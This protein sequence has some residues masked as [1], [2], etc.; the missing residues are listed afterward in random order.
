MVKQLVSNI[1]WLSHASFRIEGDGLVIYID[2]WKLKDGPKADLILITHDHHD[3]CS[4]TDVA[5]VQQEDTVIVT[6]AAAAAKLTGQVK[7]VKPGDELT[8]K[9]V[10]I[11]AVP[12]YNV[13][14]FRSPGVPFHPKE[15]SHV[16]FVLTVEGRRIYHTG[17]SDFI[18]EMRSIDV[19]VALLP[20]SGTYVMTADEALEAAAA[21]KPQV[22]IPMHVGEGIG[23]L[24]D[25]E[26]FK[27][28][29]AVA[30]EVLPLER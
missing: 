1:H 9:G 23:S 14:K 28:K 19:D 10:P 16:G 7:V 18:P 22:A 11:R 13:N 26:H 8:V 5:Q 24:A 20:V 4:P 15:S 29:A 30:V 2:P 25:A 27:E 3:H 12:A 6:I 21:I 17:D